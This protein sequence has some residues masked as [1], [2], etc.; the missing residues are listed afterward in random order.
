MLTWEGMQL[1]VNF[2]DQRATHSACC[3]FHGL[4]ERFEKAVSCVITGVAEAGLLAE[5]V[6][7]C[8][9]HQ[10]SEVQ[11]TVSELWDQTWLRSVAFHTTWDAGHLLECIGPEEPWVTSR[12]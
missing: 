11:D 3:W 10:S 4:S 1:S 5:P 6:G 7:T 8:D 12:A 2:P 9:P